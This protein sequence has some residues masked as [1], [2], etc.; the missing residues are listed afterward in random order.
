MFYPKI[1]FMNN[2]IIKEQISRWNTKL[3]TG[4]P[5][6]VITCYSDKAILLPTL[7]NQVRHNHDEI[8]DYFVNFLAKKPVC[9][10]EEHNVRIYGNVALNSGVYAFSFGDGSSARARFTFVYE[11]INNNWQIIEHHSS[12]MPE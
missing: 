10:V 9:S 8:K 2:E 4:N 5:E 11:L 1:N 7:S 3:Q 12:A 6:E